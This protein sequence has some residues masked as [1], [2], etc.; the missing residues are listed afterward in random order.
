[1]KAITFSILFLIPI[2]LSCSK[3]TVKEVKLSVKHLDDSKES[4]YITLTATNI[5]GE[6]K[7]ISM[8]DTNYNALMND[9]PIPQV[10]H[11]A[12]SGIYNFYPIFIRKNDIG[13]SVAKDMV[14]NDDFYS[15][16]ESQLLKKLDA[17]GLFSTR[18]K[19]Y[20]R[21]GINCNKYAKGILKQHKYVMKQVDSLLSL[22]KY[23][24]DFMNF[25]RNTFIY[26]YYG[27]LL[28]PFYYGK[29]ES[30]SNEYISKL[31]D[32]RD[33]LVDI[34]DF[35]KGINGSEM[36]LVYNYN[37]FLCR[38]FLNKEDEFKN[39]WDTASV[40]FKNDSRD[41]LK[42]KLLSENLQMPQIEFNRYKN[43]I[44]NKR[45]QLYLDSVFA[46]NNHYF[47]IEEKNTI[48]ED[49]T[50]RSL[51]LNDI[52][53]KNKGKIIYLEFWAS[54]CYPCRFE[55]KY[56]KTVQEKLEQNQV[57]PIFISIDEKKEQWKEAL[58]KI[59][60]TNYSHYLV[61]DKTVLNRFFNL[62]S[63]P[64]YVIID[65]AGKVINYEAIGPRRKEELFIKLGINS[66]AKP[67]GILPFGL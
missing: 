28:D 40:I 27:D 66:S 31:Y 64:K 9:L 13:L 11:Y 41:Y 16:K 44:E 62:H 6:A 39:L 48:L 60:T 38:N 43:E 35:K 8:K 4:K 14:T 47:T 26:S 7:F 1:M 34:I 63:V 29:I 55:M 49:S 65:K 45:Y 59:P 17:E 56:Y 12:A 54:W 30:N 5:F 58:G 32:L 22:Q 19:S 36:P 37:L 57:V 46:L 18:G 21:D 67:A 33:K 42:F 24:K 23:Q 20:F 25:T 52:L 10:F 61:K 50:G 53:E 51:S 15:N 3:R 2:F